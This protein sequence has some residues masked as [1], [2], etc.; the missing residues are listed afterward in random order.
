MRERKFQI[1]TNIMK[2][3]GKKD[4]FNLLELMITIL[5]LS[6]L[7][8]ICVPVF[9][10]R[11]KS[12]DKTTAMANIKI[13]EKCYDAIW[14]SR[15]AIQGK[16]AYRDYDP[17]EALKAKPEFQANGWIP[18]DGY[19]MSLEEPKIGWAD[20]EVSEGSEPIAS[21]YVEGLGIAAAPE[22][23]RIKAVW[24]A[25]TRLD[26]GS[27]DS[28]NWS[29][30][31]HKVGVVTDYYW[32][33]E[34]K[35]NPDNKYVTLIVLEKSGTA[36]YIV[37]NLGK[38]IAG[39]SFAWENG[40]GNPGDGTQEG[41]PSEE[42]PA[43]PPEYEDG[44]GGSEGDEPVTPDPPDEPVNPGDPGTPGDPGEPGN[45]GEPG[46]PGV[47]EPPDQ[48]PASFLATIVRVEPETLN[49]ASQG[50]F[51]VYITFPQGRN[52]ADTDMTS[53]RC[54]GAIGIECNVASSRLVVKFYRQDLVNVPTG[55]NVVITVSG[56]LMDGTTFVAYDSIR[57]IRNK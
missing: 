48:P 26:K 27:E 30:L 4:G 17:P 24:L 31:A 37:L 16:D 18:V 2:K 20:L 41:D 11:A 43:E 32:E 52:V 53:L 7:V 50:L 46:D 33:N 3:T 56:R 6:I 10:G 44:E 36:H 34:W 57:V 38:K 42:E 29:L 51:T 13:G 5:V 9:M 49:L 21:A 22:G 40:R 45:P 25:G 12:A 1:L 55:N 15:L 28:R 19:Y 14:Y 39:G 8:G 23:F 35:P 47:S 54:S